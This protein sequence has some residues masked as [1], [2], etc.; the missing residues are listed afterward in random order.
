[1]RA[2]YWLIAISLLSSM[3]CA[4]V[5]STDVRTSGIYASFEA[6][7][8]NDGTTK[9]HAE[10]T[11]GENSNTYL[12]LAGEDALTATQG[13]ESKSMSRNNLGSIVWYESSFSTNAEGT[14]F[15]ISFERGEDENAPN[16]EVSLPAP[17]DLTVP[18]EGDEFSMS[19]DKITVAW[20]NISDDPMTLLVSGN[21]FYGIT[22]NI[23]TDQGVFVIDAARLEPIDPTENEICTATLTLT[24]ERD[25]TIDE[26][27][28]E[29]GKFKGR[30]VRT[31]TITVAP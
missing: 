26:A 5:E 2:K 24:R 19:A 11:V 9:V 18:A 29:G 13:D 6:K 20:N 21:C 22:E 1:M 4:S 31:V 8:A 3:A 17:F 28:G 25:G 14:T 15:N 16:S 30:Q 10:L 23:V 12:D 27:Y 7:G